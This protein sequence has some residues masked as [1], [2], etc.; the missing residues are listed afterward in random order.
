MQF[1]VHCREAGG[2]SHGRQLE[3]VVCGKVTEEI[4]VTETSTDSVE[5]PHHSS[6]VTRKLQ[7]I[8]LES[9]CKE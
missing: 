1:S 4:M 3:I 5:A 2:C 8:A 6:G 7:S 9:D